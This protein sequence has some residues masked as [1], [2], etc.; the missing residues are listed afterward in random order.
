MSD[1][2][3]APA[4]ERR[5]RLR[6][7]QGDPG[8]QP[9]GS[10]RRDRNGPRFQRCRQDHHPQDHLRH[11][12]SA[13]G[14]HRVQGPEHHRERPGLHRAAGPEPRA[15]GARSVPAAVGEGQPA[16]GRLHPQGPR[17]RGARHGDGV[18]L[19][20]DPARARHAGRRPALRRPAADAGDLARHHGG[21]GPDPAR[22]AQP[23]PVAQA[24]QGDLRDRGAHQP[25]ARHHHPAGRAE[26]QR[27][28]AQRR[29]DY[30][31]VLESGRIVLGRHAA[32]G[33]ARR[34]TYRCKEFYLGLKDDG[35]RGERRWKKKKTWR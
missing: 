11:H 30:G 14:Q 26:R 24:H 10:A 29:R 9:A 15:R 12:R 34:T 31:Y 3:G 7:D 8:R 33:C 2:P 1:Q 17:R 22:R 4:A 32:N 6:P 16:H 23:G 35:V 19:F 21:A 25:R 13:Q 5:E 18:R 20:P 27:H 28:G